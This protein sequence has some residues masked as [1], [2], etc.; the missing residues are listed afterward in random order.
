M[1]KKSNKEGYVRSVYWY[2]LAM[3]YGFMAIIVFATALINLDFSI[4][5]LM[6]YVA[7]A[8]IPST[9]TF[10]AGI[11]IETKVSDKA[12]HGQYTLMIV[13]LF[14]MAVFYVLYLSWFGDTT[15]EWRRYL[16][17][18]ASVVAVIISLKIVNRGV[19]LQIPENTDDGKISASSPT[20]HN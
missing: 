10:I 20:P 12:N 8:F 15:D 16:M 7:D 18:A 17:F 6:R 2:Q 11:L 13:T 9:I 5:T 4:D 1:I 14:A 3:T 19:L